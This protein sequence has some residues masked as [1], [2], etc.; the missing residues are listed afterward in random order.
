MLYYRP[1]NIASIKNPRE[2][3]NKISWN[4]IVFLNHSAKLTLA[5]PK[6]T[7]K[8]PQVGYRT[9]VYPSANKYVRI[10]TVL[11][12]PSIGARVSI[13]I[14]NTALADALGIKN[15]I[16]STNAYRITTARYGEMFVTEL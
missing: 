16:I 13:G 9:F 10:I 3:P 2:I 5:R 7:S 14:I 6:P 1:I 15:S 12:I 4:R 11:L 8:V